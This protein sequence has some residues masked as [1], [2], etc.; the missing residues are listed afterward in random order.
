MSENE[1]KKDRRNAA[2]EEGFRAEG[3]LDGDGERSIF[4]RRAAADPDSGELVPI[5]ILY[6]RDRVE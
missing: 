3:D 4:E 5:G 2:R 6:V 1:S